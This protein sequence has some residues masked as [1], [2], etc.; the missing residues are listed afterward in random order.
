LDV[1]GVI[2]QSY[3]LD[4]KPVSIRNVSEIALLP[5]VKES[6]LKLK[7]LGFKVICIT[8]QPEISRGTLSDSDYISIRDWLLINLAVDGVY[9][10]PHDD[11]DDCQC[12]KPKIGM[13]TQAAKDFSIGLEDS[14]LIGDRWKDIEAGQ[15]V[16]AKCFFIP[17]YPK[18][19]QPVMPYFAVNSLCEAVE[20]IGKDYV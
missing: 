4:G 16:K 7:E 12:R 14:F 13:L 8:N 1:D 2:F 6:I 20:L 5:D 10:C 17:N 9:Y 11:F 15:T 19:K 3:E 18:E